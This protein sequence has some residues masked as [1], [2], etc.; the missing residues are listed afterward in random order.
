[1]RRAANGI[2]VNR[3]PGKRVRLSDQVSAA[4]DV[5]GFYGA[6]APLLYDPARCWRQP[7]P[8]PAAIYAPAAP[9]FPEQDYYYQALTA[10]APTNF[11][12]RINPGV[13]SLR[14]QPLP[15][16]IVP[17]FV[18]APPPPPPPPPP[19]NGLAIQSWHEDDKDGHFVFELGENITP[20]CNFFCQPLVSARSKMLQSLAHFSVSLSYEACAGSL[21]LQ[22]KSSARW[23]KGLLGV[24]W[25][26][27]TAKCRSMLPLNSSE[28]CKSI[29]TLP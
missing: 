4:S 20:R 13:A 12:Q 8:W 23:V 10:A 5:T 1:M 21:V 18:S 29:E 15:A 14:L 3:R 28:T 2:D 16:A 25:N 11:P 26:A 24:C 19:V 9:A 17:N 27:G 6:A 22:T 7:V